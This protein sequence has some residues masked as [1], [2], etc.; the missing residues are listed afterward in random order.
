MESPK[1]QSLKYRIYGKP[2]PEVEEMFKPLETRYAQVRKLKQKPTTYLQLMKY[3]VYLYDPGTDLNRDFVRLED[4]KNEASKL[5]GLLLIKDLA[6]LDRITNNT[7]PEML[8]VIQVLLTEVYHDIDY[9]EW[10]TLH[11][12]L[13][14][15][16]SARWEKIESKRKKGRKG[17]EIAEVSGHSKTTMDIL[18]MKSKLREDCKRIRE[19]L[20]ELNTKI[21]GDD[22]EVRDLAYRSRFTNPESFSR[23]KQMQ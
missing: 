1:F 10:H 8:D 22:K 5:S 9:R 7:Y 13:D 20:A 12:E 15:Y 2:D 3:L 6:Y 11:E 23:A 17:E 19:L 14:E 16:T 21:F 4:R 18:T